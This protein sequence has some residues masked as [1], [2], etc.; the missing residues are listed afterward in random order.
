MTP[1]EIDAMPAGAELDALVAKALGVTD[2]KPGS[3]R[4]RLFK[5][6]SDWN[7]AMRAAEKCGLFTFRCL[8]LEFGDWIVFERESRDTYK[9]IGKSPTGPLAIARAIAKLG[10]A[11]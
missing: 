10:V 3:G 9:T 11:K 8:G 1:N 4:T 7:D 6:S 2:Y 5:P